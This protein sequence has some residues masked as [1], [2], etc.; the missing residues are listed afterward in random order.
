[1][2]SLQCLTSSYQQRHQPPSVHHRAAAPWLH[3]DNNNNN[4]NSC[5]STLAT[6]QQQRHQPP[7]VHHRA[8]APWL[9]NDNN[10]NYNSCSST[11]A[12]Q[13][14]HRGVVQTSH[15]GG[16]QPPSLRTPFPLLKLTASSRPSAPPSDSP[17]CLRFG[18]WLT[19][20]TLNIHSFT[21]LLTQYV[22][23]CRRHSVDKKRSPTDHR[24]LLFGE[25]C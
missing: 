20:C 10:N 22:N 6:Q 4:Y 3:N 11:L 9:H 16:H 8:A 18:H 5:S 24:G 25:H 13:Q 14:Q 23:T 15:V 19:L 21:Y 12:T 17:K 2:T 1:M 7:S